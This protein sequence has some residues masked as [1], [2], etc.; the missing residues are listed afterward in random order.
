M[1]LNALHVE[2]TRA[3]VMLCF[4]RGCRAAGVFLRLH[5][6]DLVVPLYVKC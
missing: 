4:R 2:S 6:W 5:V 3:E 1:Y